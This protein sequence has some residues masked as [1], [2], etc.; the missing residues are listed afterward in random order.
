MKIAFRMASPNPLLAGIDAIT[1]AL[2]PTAP[3]EPDAQEP[4]AQPDAQPEAKEPEAQPEAPKKKKERQIPIPKDSATF[5]RVRAKNLKMF[6]F[7]EEGDLQVPEMRGEPAKVIQIPY[8][9][10]ATAEETLEDEQKAMEAIVEVEREFDE[11]YKLLK[12]AIAEWRATGFSADV[13][14]YQHDLQRLDSQRTQLRSPLRWTKTFKN[15]SIN[16][17]LL[18]EFYE[19]RKIGYPVEA[20]KTRSQTFEQSV[21]ADGFTKPAPVAPV[22]PAPAEVSDGEEEAE[23]FIIFSSPTDPEHGSLSPYTMVEFIHNSTKYNCVLQAYEGERLSMLGRQDIRPALLKSRSTAQMRVIASR[24]VGQPENPRELLIAI[25][26]SLISQHPRFAEDLRVTGTSSLV[27]AEP[28]DGVLGVGMGVADEQITEK[29][30]WKGTNFLGQAW[31]A[32]RAGLPP[33]AEAEEA[34]EALPAQAGGYNEH[35]KTLK[36]AKEQRA[37]VLK[38]FYRRKF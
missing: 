22:A 14:K 7:T 6:K 13:I 8:Y 29:T 35:G 4:E 12:G 21:R 28:K 1:T 16:K 26:K 38:G 30:A 3:S 10:P 24:V 27:F 23:E 18:T 37:N 11:T 32:V 25:L 19:Q 33:V 15:L 20:L 5:F 9:R 36:E 31:T 34:E 17:I 2:T